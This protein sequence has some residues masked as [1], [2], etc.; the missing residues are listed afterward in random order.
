MASRMRWTARVGVAALVVGVAAPAAWAATTWTPGP[1]A[2]SK[3]GT[4][5]GQ[6]S[7]NYGSAA[8]KVGANKIAFAYSSDAGTADSKQSV[9]ARIGSVDSGTKAVT[10]GKPKLISPKTQVAD[11]ITLGAGKTNG[12]VYTAWASQT[13]YALD[14]A[15]PRVAYYRGLVNGKWSKPVKLSAKT[16]RVDYPVVTGAGNNVYVAYTNGDTGK[17]TLKLSTDAGASFATKTLGST[18]RDLNDG[19]G[20]GGWPGVCSAGTNFGSVWLDGTGKIAV[21]V[22]KNSGGT[23]VKT[24]INTGSTAGGDDEG[25]VQCDALGSRIGFTWNQDDGVYYAEYSTATDSFVTSPTKA[26]SLPGGGYAASYS[27]SISLSGASTVGLAAP[28]CVQNGCDYTD[29]TSR[30]D[31]KWLES[32]NKG[33]AWS[34]A[35]ALANSSVAGKF[36]NDSPSPIFF[37]STTRYVIYN[38]WQANY[39]NYR[40]YLSTGLS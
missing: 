26:Y 24:S 21:V 17:V 23:I 31:L 33:V 16:G 6:Y 7:W 4:V 34:G 27:G 19:E 37:D 18:T 25:W 8:S 20:F 22:S 2:D 40:L 3:T 28:L 5:S 38:G 30:I 29:N 35:T 11:R 10:W 9:Y 32:T 12:N 36:L 1:N 39:R 13:K 14:P 15:A